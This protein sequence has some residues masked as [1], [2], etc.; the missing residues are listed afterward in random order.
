MPPIPPAVG[1]SGPLP[2]TLI[3]STMIA[4]VMSSNLLNAA[5]NVLAGSGP[6]DNRRGILFYLNRFT[7]PKIIQCR[8]FELDPDIFRNHSSA[9]QDGIILPHGPAM[10]TETGGLTARTFRA[11]RS[12]FTNSV[13]NASPSTSSPMM[14][15]ALFS[16]AACYRM[17]NRSFMELIFFSLITQLS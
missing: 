14:R 11:P 1:R 12:L 7:A 9:G 17:G 10:V 16:L 5:S 4:S 2:S 6:I 8:V 15:R 13:A 3:L